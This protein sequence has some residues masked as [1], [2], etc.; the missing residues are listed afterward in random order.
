MWGNLTNYQMYFTAL[1]IIFVLITGF[2]CLNC[3]K[4]LMTI[5][6]LMCCVRQALSPLSVEERR[7]PLLHYF[8]ITPMRTA[9]MMRMVM[10]MMNIMLLVMKIMMLYFTYLVFCLGNIGT[11]TYIHILC[12][13]SALKKGLMLYSILFMEFLN[14]Q[15]YLGTWVLS[16]VS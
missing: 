2:I 6:L 16:V 11:C 7:D 3:Q 10:M 15:V 4:Y 12:N 14:Q 5:V 9:L 8:H 13:Y 1:Q